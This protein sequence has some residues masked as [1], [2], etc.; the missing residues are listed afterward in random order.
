M[1]T[2]FLGK[3]A[4]LTVNSQDYSALGYK[5]DTELKVNAVDSTTFSASFHRT[6]AAG[7]METTFKYSLYYSQTEYLALTTLAAARTTHSVV[8][9]PT[10]TTTGMP[11]ITIPGFITSIKKGVSVDG[12]ETMD[13]EHNY[14]STVPTYDTY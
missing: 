6:A 2:F 9:G 8:F 11:R 4:S 12:L 14:G 13:I 1:A 3:S 10:G 7:L 5:V